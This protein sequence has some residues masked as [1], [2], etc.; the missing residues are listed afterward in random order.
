MA[1][2]TV[3]R[4][5]GYWFSVHK[6]IGICLAVLIIP[7][8]VTGAALVWHDWLDAQINPQRYAVSTAEAALSPA[9]YA[10]AARARAGA[11]ARLSQLRYPEEGHGPVIASLTLAREGG[12]PPQRLSVWL[13][14]GTGQVLDAADPNSG[15][16]RVFHNLHGNLLVSGGTGRAVVGWVGVFMFISCLTGIWLWW[17]ISGSFRRGFRWKRQN[18]TNANI[19]HQVGFWVMVP[20][21]MLSFTGIWISAPAMLG[22][23]PP[24]PA[25]PALLAQTALT[26]DAALAA[27]TPASGGGSLVSVSWPT[28]QVSEWKFAF[29]RE[30]G[31]A[32]VAVNDANGEVTPPRPPRPET[33]ARLMRR[34]HDGTGMGTFWQIVIFIGGIIPAILAITGLVMWWRSRGWKKALAKKRR[35]KAPGDAAPQPAE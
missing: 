11:D 18:S 19:H 16:V 9:R 33:T 27:A 7:I 6:W 26:P 29:A 21:A 31:A 15:L 1:Q 12:G 22:N 4:L 2:S 30:G 8:S 5:R 24:R 20:L 23:Q 3:L 32:E 14:P 25:P 17:P 34:L 13:D 28:E 10:E 35:E